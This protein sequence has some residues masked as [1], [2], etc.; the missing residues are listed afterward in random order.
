MESV[1]RE[2]QRALRR[3]TNWYRLRCHLRD[4]LRL[5]PQIVLWCR[6][7]RP[8]SRNYVTQDQYNNVLAERAT[9]QRIQDDNPNLIWLYNVLRAEGLQPTGDQPV[10]GMK[11]WLLKQENVSEAGWR[12]IANG[13][14]QDFRHI[15]DFVDESGGISGRHAY[16]PKWVRVLGTLRR[17][18]SVPRPLLG[19]FAH[20]AY[21]GM[22][23]E[24]CD[25]VRFRGVMFQPGI[26]RAILDEGERRL[27]SGSHHRFIEE[28]VVEVM[29]WLE[30]EKPVLDK[31]Q[32]RKG[33]QYLADRAVRWRVERE[34]RDTL[35]DLTWESLLPETQIGPWRVVPL[36]D[37]WQLRREALSRRN[38]ADQYLGDCLSG[39]YRL[40]SVC[41]ER[42][43]PV[44]TVGI[45]LEGMSWKV[46]GL[47]GFANRPVREPLLGL[48]DE[49]VRRYSEL[50]ELNAPISPPC[51]EA[52]ATT[53]VSSEGGS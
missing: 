7:G 11:A 22:R 20:D 31:N 37:A 34:A 2:L 48:D 19:L 18:R 49:V 45:E 4:A 40:F 43:E 33:W 21:D 50:W 13:K 6:K 44:A 28:E 14:E 42:G 38:C 25:R 23:T 39:K 36:T 10:A 8:T 41:S 30:A 51:A 1:K 17:G 29:T 52:Y 16:L 24:A 27:A 35:K 46:F 32:L 12:L 15:I 26:L 3:S 5:D 9:Y 53:A 47:R